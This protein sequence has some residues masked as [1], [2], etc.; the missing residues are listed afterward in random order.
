[1]QR[2]TYKA[3]SPWITPQIKRKFPRQLVRIDRLNFY[4]WC[5]ESKQSVFVKYVKSISRSFCHATCLEIT[6]KNAKLSLTDR[7]KL[8]YHDFLEK[9]TGFH[10]NTL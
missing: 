4:T 7:A 3:T 8:P 6:T 9:R 2:A 5:Q 1:L 10:Y